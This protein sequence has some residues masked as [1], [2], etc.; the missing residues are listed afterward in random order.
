M[1]LHDMTPKQVLQRSYYLSGF[2]DA[3]TEVLRI[4]DEVE[5]KETFVERVK[6]MRRKE[7]EDQIP[8]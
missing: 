5:D 7:N 1:K 3:V 6:E 4:Y 8:V 2:N